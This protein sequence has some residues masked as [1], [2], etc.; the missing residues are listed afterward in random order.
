MKLVSKTIIVC[1]L[2]MWSCAYAED[3]HKL[4]SALI[5]FDRNPRNVDE[6]FKEAARSEKSKSYILANLILSMASISSRDTFSLAIEY[7]RKAVEK[8]NTNRKNYAKPFQVK[9]T[10]EYYRLTV[11]GNTHISLFKEKKSLLFAYSEVLYLHAKIFYNL[12]L[13]NLL[14]E[15]SSSLAVLSQYF[16]NHEKI[17]KKRAD[18]IKLCNIELNKDSISE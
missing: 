6:Y 1:F 8:S 18:E 10:I 11:P 7:A 2:F 14:Y 16:Y 3:P 12:K 9:P 17:I 15:A 13:R 5:Q 4:Q